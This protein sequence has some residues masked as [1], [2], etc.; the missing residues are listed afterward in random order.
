[1]VDLQKRDSRRIREHSRDDNECT[2]EEKLIS[3]DESERLTKALVMLKDEEHQIIKMRYGLDGCTYTL[4]EIGERLGMNLSRVRRIQMR[5]LV[6]L[7]R[8]VKR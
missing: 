2:Q 4:K 1:M 8:L 3:K 5:A 6:K 7:K